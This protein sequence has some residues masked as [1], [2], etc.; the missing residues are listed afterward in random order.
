M[1]R[2]NDAPGHK[3]THALQK[4]GREIRRG[5]DALGGGPDGRKNRLSD[6]QLL[7][8]AQTHAC[9]SRTRRRVP[10][11]DAR[12]WTSG[13]TRRWLNRASLKPCCG[14]AIVGRWALLTDV[15]KRLRNLDFWSRTSAKRAGC[16]L[17]LRSR[18]FGP[19]TNSKR[20]LRS[21]SRIGFNFSSCTSNKA[22]ISHRLLSNF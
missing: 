8:F 18:R 14:D 20:G 7:I 11:N 3:R 5:N 12:I 13:A 1:H 9:G 10:R 22:R 16:S 17:V 2:G 4:I 19:K 6:F 15:A 21:S